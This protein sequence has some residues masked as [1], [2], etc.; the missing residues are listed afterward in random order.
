[1]QVS[2]RMKP[3]LNFE[4]NYV[5]SAGAGSGKTKTLVD[6][7]I[8]LIEQGVCPK[9]IVAITFT[10]K[11]GGELKDRIEKEIL[12]RITSNHIL[13]D[14]KIA[15]YMKAVQEISDAPIA[16]FHTFCA[17]LLHE[18]SVEAN[19]VPSF[20]I[21]DEYEAVAILKDIVRKTIIKLA[22]AGDDEVGMWLKTIGFQGGN[23]LIETLLNVYQCIRNHGFEIKGLRNSS[24][25]GIYASSFLNILCLVD[26]NYSKAKM[27][28]AS[29]DFNDLLIFARRLLFENRGV[30]NFYK[31]QYKKI[32]VDEFQDTNHLQAE[33]IY[34]L[35]ER[36]DAGNNASYIDNLGDSK[37][38]VV[39]DMKQSIYGFRGAEITVFQDIIKGSEKDSLVY[40]T[41]NHRSCRGIVSFVNT[42]FIH[43][44]SQDGIFNE[45]AVQ[46]HT[47]EETDDF[48]DARVEVILFGENK[49]A[50]EGRQKEADALAKRIRQLVGG[51]EI[52]EKGV[53]KR[54]AVFSDIAILFRTLND[55]NI[56]EEALKGYDIPYYIVK[57]RGFYHCQEVIDIYN[58]LHHIE[59]WNSRISLAG[60]LRS[61]FV[62][63]M[64]ET[65]FRL[66]RTGNKARELH[67]GF[68]NETD[69]K[70]YPEDETEKICTARR[71][72]VGWKALKDNLTIAE[73]IEKILADSG[74]LA[75]VIPTFQGE[76]KAANIK[77]LI[78]V[79]RGFEK[80]GITTLRDFIYYLKSL[81]DEV[82]HESE[83]QIATEGMD[84]VRLMTVHQAKGLEFPVVF[85]PDISRRFP[86]N[87]DRVLFH[88]STGITIK[89]MDENGEQ[90]LHSVFAEAKVVIKQ[91]A[92]EE[93]VRIFY[94]ACTRARDYLV[95]SRPSSEGKENWGA[96]LNNIL[97]QEIDEFIKKDELTADIDTDGRVRVRFLRG[98]KLAYE[99]KVLYI[100]TP[101]VVP[102]KPPLQVIKDVFDFTPPLPSE[103]TV[104]AT[105]LADFMASPDMFSAAGF[106]DDEL[107]RKTAKDMG[108]LIHIVLEKIDYDAA[109]NDL[110]Y[111]KRFIKDFS[112]GWMLQ[113]DELNSIIL[114][115]TEFFKSSIFMDVFESDEVCRELPFFMPVR[116]QGFTLYIK[117]VIDLLY[118]KGSKWKIIDYKYLEPKES[119]N[120][121]NQIKIYSLAVR[122]GF[123]SNVESSLLFIKDGLYISQQAQFDAKLFK[124]EITAAGKR[125]YTLTIDRT[126]LKTVPSAMQRQ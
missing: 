26:D 25:H 105:T 92:A 72:V 76:Q 41:D 116:E 32:M 52:F 12:T 71:W 48:N 77:K 59:C 122:E 73:L 13:S 8:S 57:G 49:N 121:K 90:E 39:G 45:N 17:K 27:E 78:E 34:L 113:K 84:V 83:A 115:V 21:I 37:L 88:P 117:G 110:S 79:A 125:L 11:A 6:L 124:K 109:R 89:D 46:K 94:V 20:K 114:S 35:A 56:Y 111:I 102:E 68:Y 98:D 43:K 119:D 15:N 4:Q 36:Y 10:E 87:N 51:L 67:E 58:V 85:I 60:F 75:A 38:I 2:E 80:K 74:Y 40:L 53:G 99:H 22:D 95:L 31:R 82:P 63:L 104:S 118:R 50:K 1:M 106:D 93:S 19:I 101:P 100:Q 3:L 91:N 55:V 44:D 30:R 24:A 86:Q 5:I 62:G 9:E 120:Y 107:D 47:R 66:C 70:D 61:P 64:D 18:H 14:E 103:F 42:L 65:L 29:L 123:K 96:M 81:L 28:M 16:T 108:N 23:G 126:N 69:F 54:N 112:K 33:I 97:K 7:Y